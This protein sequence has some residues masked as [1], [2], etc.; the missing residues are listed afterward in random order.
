MTLA[1]AL[2]YA[3]RGKPV[4]P[5]LLR[6]NSNTGKLDKRPLVPWGAGASTDP[7]QITAW[8]KRWPD[9]AIGVPTGQRSGFVVL[10][11]DVK[12]ARAY[13]YDTLDAL[14]LSI[15]PD[16]PIAHTSSG[17]LHIYFGCIAQEIRNS[18]GEDGLGPGLDVRGEGGYIVVPSPGSGYAWD[19]HSNL[20]TVAL[21]PAPPW[22]GHHRQKQ[23]KSSGP[24]RFN[25]QAILQTACDNIRRAGNGARHDTL[26][27]EVFTIAAMVKAGALK[28]HDARHQLEAA[29][30][31]MS[32]ASKGDRTKAAR[33][34]ADAW[35]GGLA[36]GKAAR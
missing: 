2:H 12:D 7:A 4:F 26:N 19:P 16:T 30:A 14:G 27:R 33:D 22:L 6:R 11:I 9:A 3:E 15:L 8:W 35:R 31:A 32:W 25:P 20:D 34:F 23:K 29:A 10:D 28:E 24:S 17:G 18:V 21:M 13:G 36:K 1:S 5:V